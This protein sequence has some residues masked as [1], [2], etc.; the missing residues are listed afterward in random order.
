V[1]RGQVR[2]LS[3][4]A[5]LRFAVIEVVG[6][7]NSIL[8][9]T[10]SSGSYLLRN[11][12]AGA[13]MLR[14]THIDH[15]SH[16]VE[17][18]IGD[19]KEVALD[20]DLELRPVRLP[21][22]TTRGTGPHI[23][24]D[25]VAVGSAA[26]GP[27]NVRVMESTPGVAEM[28]LAEM[29]RLPGNEPPDPSDILYV[30]GGAADLKLVL[31]DG[32]P[33]YAPFH[34]GGLI[35]PLDPDVLHGVTLYLGGAPARYDGGL[36]YVM[37]LETR[38][39]R[40]TNDHASIA[41][42][43]LSARTRVEGPIIDRVTYL[44]G[45][46]AVHGLG[47]EPF[48]GGQGSFP[49]LYGD[50]LGRID[51]DLGRY[52]RI[53]TTG[54]WN[55]ESVQLDSLSGYNSEAI[56]G[57]GAGSLRYRGELGASNADIRV[58]V[59]NFHTQLPVGGLRPL[60][61]D[62]IARRVRVGI[63]LE[64]PTGGAQLHYGLQFDRI[65]YEYR[66]WPRPRTIRDDS[67]LL[68]ADGAGEVAG[69]YIDAAW[70]VGSRLQLRGGLRADVFSLDPAPRFAPRA[71][72][73]FVLNDRASLTLAVGKYRQYVRAS[74]QT[75]TQ[76]GS[77]P[78]SAQGPALNVASSSHVVLTLDQDL[79]EGI[80]LGL[81]SFYKDFDGLP[82]PEGERAQSSGLD[83]W[84]RR[85]NGRLTGWLGYSLAWMW[86]VDEVTDQRNFAGRHLI[87]AGVGGPIG[88]PGRFDLRVA[89]GAGLPY[90]AIPE[91]ETPPVFT[92]SSTARLL[93]PS[94]S[95]SDQIP[96]GPNSPD[97]PYLRVDLQVGRTFVADLRGFAFE[98]TP[99]FKVLNALDRRDAMFY[100]FDSNAET[101][102]ARPLAPLP[103]LPILG[104]EW[105]F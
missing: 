96:G 14:A 93:A 31:L 102:S 26:L 39:G 78:D 42:D 65:K 50:A 86:T 71:A 2:S 21:P 47:A 104:F 62:G 87:S 5:P 101:P 34:L 7:G 25:T 41:M 28:G 72:A 33:V 70:Q 77:I 67:L 51:V 98:L 19:G 56:W 46:R 85:A 57:N 53:T 13:Q 48:T 94:F 66:A 80:R 100:H 75:L 36:S 24:R 105:K 73:T 68:R 84:L 103:I 32:A 58:G 40:S 4:G 79:G 49:Y 11:V 44:A 88:Q 27:A 43:L 76:S 16:E 20:F 29:A 55:R 83:L 69:A 35:N 9:P 74:G 22:I 81:E 8:A 6:A 37:D 17:I 91:P 23:Q 54:F 82:M 92:T 30:R 95:A 45:G 97:E 15:A 60:M 18:F 12:P 99:Y 89:Y 59:G 63:N 61:T 3:T 64:R 90:T 38:A 1:V 10:D 52:G